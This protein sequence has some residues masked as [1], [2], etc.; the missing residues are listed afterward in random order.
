[1]AKENTFKNGAGK[2]GSQH[3]DNANI[4]ISIVLHK[5]QVQIDQRPQHIISSH[6]EPNRRESHKYP[7]MHWHRRSL[8]KYKSNNTDTES[9]N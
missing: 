3:D 9:N 1:M 8:P 2:A 7:K 6:A 4:S 5:T